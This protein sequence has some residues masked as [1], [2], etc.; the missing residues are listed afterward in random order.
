MLRMS[1]YKLQPY[2]PRAC[3][4]RFASLLGSFEHAA[5]LYVLVDLT[6]KARHNHKVKL[7]YET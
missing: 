6:L 5:A 1:T 7:N 2:K 3:K 4:L